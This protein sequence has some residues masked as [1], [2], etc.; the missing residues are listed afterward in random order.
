MVGDD[1]DP[2]E[3]VQEHRERLLVIIRQSDDVF[4]RACAWALLDKYTPAMEL[5][6]LRKELETVARTEGPS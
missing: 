1:V 6:E 5:D 2:A 3:Y 4:T